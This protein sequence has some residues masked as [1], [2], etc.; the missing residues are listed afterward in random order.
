MCATQCDMRTVTHREMHNSSGEIL[1]AVAAGESIRVTDN[2][3]VAALIVP[4]PHDPVEDLIEK[5]QARPAVRRPG[6]F[7]AIERSTSSTSTA[8]IIEDLRGPW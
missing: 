1:R 8:E 7:A 6:R 2:G 3:R 5:G 4:P